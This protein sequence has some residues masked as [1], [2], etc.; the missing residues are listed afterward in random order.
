ML[1]LIAQQSLPSYLNVRF[2][3]NTFSS[4]RIF[5]ERYSFF[6]SW[7]ELSYFVFIF[8][9]FLSSMK[10]ADSSWK[11]KKTPNLMA[12][13]VAWKICKK[14][15]RMDRY[16]LVQQVCGWDFLGPCMIKMSK[17]FETYS[18]IFVLALTFRSNM[19]RELLELQSGWWVLFFQSCNWHF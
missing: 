13:I 8:Q 5:R 9:V 7:E 17:R 2:D 15:M 6:L 11:L 16:N 3:K 18:I 19:T 10:W 1:S 4:A 14:I 12:R